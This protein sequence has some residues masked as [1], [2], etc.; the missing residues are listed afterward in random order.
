MRVVTPYEKVL[1][2]VLAEDINAEY[3]MDPTKDMG[4]ASI[5]GVFSCT[6]N[7]GQRN[8]NLSSRVNR[9]SDFPHNGTICDSTVYYSRIG[10]RHLGYMKKLRR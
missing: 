7:G 3:T 5:Y 4:K 2:N 1:L 9:R 10:D 8:S 6:P